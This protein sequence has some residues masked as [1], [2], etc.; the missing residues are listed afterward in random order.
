MFFLSGAGALVFETVWF[1]QMGLVL[2]NSVWSAALVV[3]AFMAGLA[4]GNLAAPRLA[5]RSRN[6]VKS[7]AA[8]E[9]VA[10]LSGAA[11][12]LVFP[13]LPA[14]SA[15]LLAP[16][17]EHPAALGA[18]R[19]GLAFFLMVIPAAALGATLPLLS[20]PLEAASGSYGF[21]LGRLYGIN[22]LG[23]VA[24]TLAAELVLIPAL[25]LRGSGL[26]A[27]ACNLAAAAIAL[28]VARVPAFKTAIP[29]NSI[30]GTARN[31]R[32]LIA[33]FL[34][35]ALLLGLEVLWFR[36]LL[37]FESGTT[38]MFATMLAVVLAG[39]GLGGMLASRWARRGWSPAAV[40]RAAAGLAA[41]GV[42][43]GYAA[44][45]AHWAFL[46]T[47]AATPP[48]AVSTLHALVLMGPVSLLSGVLFTALGDVLRRGM[49]DAA[50]ATARLTVANT[51]GAVAGSL[52]A[53]FLLLP[54]LGIEVSFFA[55]AALY[56]VTALLVPGAPARPW[57]RFAPAAFAVA[58]LALFPLGRMA[59]EHYRRVEAHFSARLVAAREGIVET[60]FY[61]AYDFLGEPAYYRLVTNSHAMSSTSPRAQRYMRLFAYLPGALHP[62]IESALVICFGV[63]STLSAVTDLPDV[64]A[65]DVVDV[66]RDILELS[67]LAYRAPQRHPLRDPRV[68]SHVED[69]RFFLQHTGRRYDLITAEPPPPKVARIVSLYTREYFELLKGRLNPGGIASYWLTVHQLL[70]EESLAIVRAFC[71]AFPD[72]SLWSGVGLEWILVGSRDGISPAPRERIARLFAH[73]PTREHFRRMAI[74]APEYLLA[75]FIAD[76]KALREVAAQTPPLEDDFPR[77]LSS[78]LPSGR[79]EPLYAALLDAA[80]SRERLR[81]SPWA[82][83]VLPPALIAQSDTAFRERVMLDALAYPEL[84]PAGSS[85][86][87]DVAEVARRGER[88]ALV[89]WLLGSD[90]RRAEIAR[91]HPQAGAAAAHLAID[92]L[93]GRR[94]PAAPDEARFRAMSARTQL[95]T[96]F[97]H[98]VSGEAG[99]ART[100]MAWLPAE[101]RQSEPYRSFLS[102]AETSCA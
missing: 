38:L 69:G 22:T 78:T 84:R 27:A 98:C 95:V 21:A 101:R 70:P 26:A 67:D 40:A 39:I 52:A 65:I 2:G 92:A 66:S 60:A 8:L 55:L 28:Q 46:V 23:A 37:L 56:G 18:L 42:A 47:S 96:V 33:A 94:A 43:A 86:W 49:S 87:G 24:G 7:Y 5:R 29:E 54:G 31:T 71:A 79:A 61:L 62:R 74:E 35:G 25:G 3:A 36:L 68:K 41:A 91:R 15:P 97:H 58:A 30:A 63:G 9:A 80:A 90:E 50:A 82:A 59:G 72:C 75:Q 48:M 20:K 17:T 34:S 64:K 93:A 99:R 81:A 1:N 102:W 16:F 53:A 19:L 73:E 11:M 83:A 51:T 100:L 76:A 10:A 6:L 89:R 4:L 85:A 32:V 77:R 13:A 45:P 88:A 57:W 44:I 12:V 14:L